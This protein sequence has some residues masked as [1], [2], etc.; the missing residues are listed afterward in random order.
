MEQLP[1]LSIDWLLGATSHTHPRV[2]P[3]YT[4]SGGVLRSQRQLPLSGYRGTQPVHL[5]NQAGA[6]LQLG[7]WGDLMETMWTYV[8]CGHL[9]SP[10]TG[11]RL[12]DMTDLLCAVWRHPDAGL[13]ELG[14]DADY[15]TSKLSCWTAF[16]RTL[17]LATAGHLPNRHRERWQRAEEE[18]ARFIETRLWSETK[19][20]Y[21]MKAGNDMLDCGVLLAARRGYGDPQGP[22]MQGT[23]DAITRELHADGPLF[24]RYSGMRE[25]ENA[26][27]ACS[28]WMVQA[29]ALAGRRDDAG[30]LMD[31]AVTV[32]NDV[33]LFSEELEPGTRELRGNLPQALTHL[34]LLNAATVLARSDAD[35]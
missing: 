4:L 9:L 32:A 2:D 11:E 22:R 33:G 24:F 16:R 12:A 26:F 28:F 27:L 5:G 8:N 19:R 18:V 1:H 23:I 20:S 34:S 31:S 3:V 6:Q 13:W 25:Q 14:D 15:M 29:L 7:G 35:G 17:D 10:A 21:V 30:Q